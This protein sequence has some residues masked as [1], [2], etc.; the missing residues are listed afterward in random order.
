LSVSLQT[1]YRYHGEGRL[2]GIKVADRTLRFTRQA[3]I[4][5]LKESE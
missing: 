3:V 4:S 1:V 5:I 2:E